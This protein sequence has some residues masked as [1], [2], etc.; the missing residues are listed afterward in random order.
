MPRFITGDEL[1]NLKAYVSTAMD[2]S[3]KVNCSELLVEIDKQKSIQKLAIAKSTKVA[4][5]LAD[6]TVLVHSLSDEDNLKLSQRHQWKESRLKTGQSFVGLAVSE[7]GVYSCTSNGALRST[8]GEELQ[9]NLTVLPTRLCCWR[10]SPDDRSF[11]YGGEEVEVSLW[12]TE[13]TFTHPIKPTPGPSEKRKRGSDLLPAETWRARNVPNDSLSLRQ[14]VHV[15]SLS[16][17]SLSICGP[18]T[19]HLIAGTNDGHVRRYDTRV[20]RR[21]VAD[22]RSIAK[23]GAIKAV[24]DGHAEYEVFLS[25]QASNLFAL[26]LRTGRVLYGYQ[27]ISGTITSL[28][29]APH[30]VGSTSLDRFFRLHGTASEA[31]AK[32]GK[33]QTLEKVYTKSIPTVVVW[34]SSYEDG[35]SSAPD[36]DGGEEDQ[37]WEGMENAEDEGDSDDQPSPNP[38]HKKLHTG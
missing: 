38:L 6:G 14:P 24:E 22:W 7:G 3:I 15:T 10:L 5:A 33:G 4:S 29:C 25:D 8:K 13:R 20:A 9:H 26:D 30:Y 19:A 17:L 21:P 36:D 31:S 34:D 27:G 2:G 28:A 16:H 1:G 18:S 37:V 11:A 32:A 23:A 35:Q 12:D